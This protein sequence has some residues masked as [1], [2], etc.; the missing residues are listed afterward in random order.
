MVFSESTYKAGIVEDARFLVGANSVSYPIEDLTRNVNRR[1]D[2][3]KNIIYLTD[4]RW[5]SAE[6]TYS[7]NLVSGTQG[8]TIPRTHIKITRV[9][10]L[11][12]DGNSIRLTPIDKSDVSTSIR[13]FENVDA[14]PRYYE[15]SGQ[16]INLYPAPNY[17]STN[18]L[19]WWFQGVPDYFETTDTTAEADLVQTVDRYLSVGAALDYAIAKV[20]SNKN[21]LDAMLKDLKDQLGSILNRRNGDENIVLKAKTISGR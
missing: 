7:L 15:L 11:D 10:I 4:G 12:S 3:A 14:Q 17:N 6:S 9:E 8:Y 20:L 16:T 13:D 1:W 18:G 5:Q 19:T 21:D 2:E